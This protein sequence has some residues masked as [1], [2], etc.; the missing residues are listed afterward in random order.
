MIGDAHCTE[1]TEQGFLQGIVIIV[2]AL[3]GTVIDTSAGLQ[4][5]R[6]ETGCFVK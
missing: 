3:F 1:M 4:C 2:P 6:K 5:L